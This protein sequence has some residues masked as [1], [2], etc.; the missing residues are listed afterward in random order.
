MSS[1]PMVL[2][3]LST[4]TGDVERSKGMAELPAPMEAKTG[5]LPVCLG[6]NGVRDEYPRTQRESAAKP[7]KIT[8]RIER[9]VGA[10]A[11]GA[12]DGAC[13]PSPQVV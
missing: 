8:S 10:E 13:D 6:D 1:R 9:V 5:T 2:Q 12:M 3:F 7:K 11:G 4:W